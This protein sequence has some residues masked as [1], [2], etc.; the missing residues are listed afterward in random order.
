MAVDKSLQELAWSR[1]NR[2]CEYCQV[3]QAFDA[4]PL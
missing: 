4:L 3:S 2:Q 1:A